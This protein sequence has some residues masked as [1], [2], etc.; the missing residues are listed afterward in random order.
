MNS[1]LFS[2]GILWAADSKS[3]ADELEPRLTASGGCASPPLLRS[4]YLCLFYLIANHPVAEN[5]VWGPLSINNSSHFKRAASDTQLTS[6]VDRQALPWVHHDQENILCFSNPILF[7]WK[8]DLELESLWIVCCHHFLIWT[9]FFF[10]PK[11]QNILWKEGI[12]F[13]CIQHHYHELVSRH[14]RMRYCCA[15]TLALHLPPDQD[16]FPTDCCIA[17]IRCYWWTFQRKE[18]NV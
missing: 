18:R 14:W 5:N 2:K 7:F 13:P 9:R 15:K 16:I 17:P 6:S 11:W 8:S 10:L 12:L 4:F 3:L 1:N